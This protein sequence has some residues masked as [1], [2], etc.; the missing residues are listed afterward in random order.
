MTKRLFGSVRRRG[1]HYYGRY[2]VNGR[3]YYTPATRTISET[4]H[5]LDLVHAEILTGTWTPTP[6]KK[7]GDDAPALR[8]CAGKVLDYL[9]NSGASPNTIRTYKSA[10]ESHILP[11]MGDMPVTGITTH[12]AASFHEYLK[13][14][15]ITEQTAQNVMGAYPPHQQI[16]MP[17]INEA[18][19]DKIRNRAQV[20]QTLLQNIKEF[21]GHTARLAELL[22]IQ[23]I[24]L[25]LCHITNRQRGNSAQTC[26]QQRPGKNKAIVVFLHQE[27]N[28]ADHRGTFLDFIKNH[29]CLPRHQFH[30]TSQRD[31]QH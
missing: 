16:T 8:Q 14:K 7:S 9:Q 30:V 15:R 21:S 28:K 29:H 5:L 22:K 19:V 24:H 11:F 25:Q 1:K 13:S 27:F 20:I 4:R 10:P 18:V 2:R 26:P 31:T 17:Q 6:R 3:D 23:G 12:T